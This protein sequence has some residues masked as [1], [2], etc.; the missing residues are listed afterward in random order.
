M[1]NHEEICVATGGQEWSMVNY[2]PQITRI[3]QQSED[4][5]RYQVGNFARMVRDNDVK[6]YTNIEIFRDLMWK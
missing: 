4:I 5:L 3:C 6:A 2:N 1:V